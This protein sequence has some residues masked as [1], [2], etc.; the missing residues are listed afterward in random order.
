[1]FFFTRKAVEGLKEGRFTAVFRFFFFF[2]L[3]EVK[4]LV[5]IKKTLHCRPSAIQPVQHYTSFQCDTTLHNSNS[6]L[7]PPPGRPDAI[8]AG[9][10]RH[11]TLSGHNVR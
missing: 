2:F 11:P 3:S 6:I 4:V 1:M 5:V 9:L 7:N 10:T 8:L